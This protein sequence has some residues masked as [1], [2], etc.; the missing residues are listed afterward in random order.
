MGL[1]DAIGLDYKIP[2]AFIGQ[3]AQIQQAP[4]MAEDNTP[5]TDPKHPYLAHVEGLTD[6]YYETA[7][8][9]KSFVHD[10]AK[11]GVDVTQ[12]D[13]S[14]PG[15]GELFKT[16]HKLDAVLQHTANDLAN[17]N[18]IDKTMRQ[19]YAENKITYNPGFDPTKQMSAETDPREMFTP[20]GLAPATQNAANDL[21]QTYYTQRDANTKNQAVRN[22]LIDFYEKRAKEDPKNARYY[23]QQIA[24]IH[25]ATA[26]TAYQQLIPHNGRGGAKTQDY[27]DR[28]TLIKQVK[29]GILTNDQ[30]PLNL[31]KLQPGIESAEYV[32]DGD[33]MGIE[34]YQ[35]GSDQ[36]SFI[37]LHSPDGGAGEINAMLNKITGQ[38]KIPNEKV[39]EF[40][41][42]VKIP[43]SKAKP[44]LDSLKSSLIDLEKDPMKGASSLEQLGKVAQ[45][46]G[47]YTPEGEQ[48]ISMEPTT[49]W[50]WQST[51]TRIKVTF[52]KKD[53]KGNPTTQTDEKEII[54]GDNSEWVNSLIKDNATTIANSLGAGFHD[55][56]QNETVETDIDPN[57]AKA[58][59][60]INK[61]LPK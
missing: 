28:A 36:P 14:Q 57:K 15:G 2:Q 17:S 42:D 1:G 58:Q 30:T 29:S 21:A 51:P 55:D 50:P 20:T 5:D 41:T 12:P 8:L 27:V 22:P 49:R 47:L 10:Q 33:R 39:F 11:K 38:A 40:D 35:K 44:F 18:D 37:D 19:L 60:L 6:K 7:G 45:D 54:V 16:Y 24:A 3:Q 46:V 31:L 53:K 61:Y 43:K 34:I 59:E 56:E 32:N 13:Y 4:Q 48:I 23:E 9:L 25:P 52:Y 26:Q